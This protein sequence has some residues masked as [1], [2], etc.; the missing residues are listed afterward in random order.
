M[1]IKEMW[2][3]RVTRR[4]VREAAG[5]LQAE[6]G[7]KALMTAVRRAFAAGGAGRAH[8]YRFWSRVT[9]EIGADM[10]RRAIVAEVM[11]RSRTEAALA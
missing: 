2:R 8:E 10:R 1:S 11:K 4:R 6:L 3:W 5:I 9:A 7:E